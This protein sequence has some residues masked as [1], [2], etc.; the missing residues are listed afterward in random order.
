ML[1][2]QNEIDF[3]EFCAIFVSGGD[4]SVHEV[5]NGMLHRKDKK[6]LPIGIIPNGS[7]NDTSNSVSM[8]DLDKS[9]SALP[10]GDLF[11]F[12]I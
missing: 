1:I 11:K 3:D 2:P 7:G 5:V 4:G 12:D 10:K 8:G 9:L 6:R